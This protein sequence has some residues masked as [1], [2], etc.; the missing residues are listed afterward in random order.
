MLCFYKFS[1]LYKAIKK[2]QFFSNSIKVILGFG[3]INLN[4]LPTKVKILNN[5]VSQIIYI[6]IKI[7]RFQSLIYFIFGT[8]SRYLFHSND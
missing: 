1:I 8:K 5:T 6:K 4:L 7:D 2:N 3:S